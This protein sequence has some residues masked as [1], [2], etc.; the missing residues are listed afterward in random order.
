[1]SEFGEE[2]LSQSR[3]FLLDDFLPKIENSLEKLSAEQVWWRANEESNSAGNLILHLTGNIRQWIISGIGGAADTRFRQQEFDERKAIPPVEL[4]GNLRITVEEA[5]R[6]LENFEP[7]ALLEK[8]I[9][10]GRETTVLSAVYHVVEHFSMHTGQIIFVA[11]MLAGD[12]AFY[13]DAGGMAIPKWK[14]TDTNRPT[15]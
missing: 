14:K 10:Q 8:R 2:F 3:S 12:T 9:I 5:C 4:L 7:S 1:M 6:V 15:F 11:K 13:D